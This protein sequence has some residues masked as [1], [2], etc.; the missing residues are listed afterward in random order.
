MAAI[1]RRRPSVQSLRDCRVISHRGEHDNKTVLENTLPA[2]A[3]ARQAGVWGIECDMAEFGGNTHLMLEIKAEDFPAP[4]RQQHILQDALAGLEPGRDYHFL[5]L[6]PALFELVAFVPRNVCFPVAELNGSA[7]SR[8]SLE[9]GY[10]GITGHYLLLNNAL[11]RA[12]EAAGQRIGTG[13]VDSRN[14][15]FRELNRGVTWIFSNRAV[16]VQ[17]VRDACLRPSG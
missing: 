8:L 15:L 7:L 6:D 2:F 11:K 10:G 4:Q 14:C 3:R 5:A 12:H 17:A 9:R 1:P 16:Q 13:F